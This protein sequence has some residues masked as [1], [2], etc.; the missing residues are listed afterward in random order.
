MD[1][2][3]HEVGGHGTDDVGIV[4]L[5]GGLDG[6]RGVAGPAVG[7]GG[8]GGG[9]VVADEAVEAFGAVGRD[10]GPAQAARRVAVADLDGADDAQLAV[11]AAPGAAGHGIIL[12]A[13]RQRGLVDLDEARQR[14]AL[15]IDHGFAQLGG[16]QPGAA[17]RTD[18]ELVLE[19][20][21]RD[22]VRMRRHQVGGPE[23]DG[24]RE[25]A[26]VQDGPRRHRGLAMA[27]RALE[28]VGLAA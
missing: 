5:D 15:G 6:G 11:V 14:V 4:G 24:E 10:L 18:P 8:A 13:E 19:L 20:Q 2:G 7:L 9:D 21:R 26:A 3:Q 25:L 1:P 28:R 27:A 23:P 17:I 12:G 16:E 22:P